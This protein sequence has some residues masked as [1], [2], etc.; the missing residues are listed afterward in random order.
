MS[1]N[2]LRRPYNLRWMCAKAGVVRSELFSLSSSQNTDAMLKAD[3]HCVRRII[4]LV[5]HCLRWQLHAGRFGTAT[6]VEVAIQL[7]GK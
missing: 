3:I 6:R 4:K 7:P 2:D 1:G 5:C